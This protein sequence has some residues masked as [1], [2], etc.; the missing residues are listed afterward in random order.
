MNS[1]KTALRHAKARFTEQLLKLTQTAREFLS[2][3][4][5]QSAPGGESHFFG[6]LI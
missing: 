4:E 3:K 6:E 5:T 1:R 2:A